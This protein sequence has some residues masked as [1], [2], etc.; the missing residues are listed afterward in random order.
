MKKKVEL[1]FGSTASGKSSYAFKRALAENAEIINADSMQIYKELPILTAQPSAFEKE[2]VPHH[3][4]GILETNEVFSVAKWLEK[5]KE[6]IEQIE[7]PF[8]VGGTG[9]YFKS[10][11]EGLSPIPDIEP[12]VRE[13]VRKMPLDEIKARL[14][15]FPYQDPQRLRRAFEVFIQTGKPLS[16]FQNLP[17]IKVVEADFKCIFI[18]PKREILYEK[19]ENRFYKMVDMGVLEEIENFRQAH[20]SSECFLYHALGL[21]NIISFMDGK[22]SFEKAIE[23]TLKETRHYAKRQNTFFRNQFKSHSVQEIS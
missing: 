3:L 17:K 12:E 18:N 8:L 7:K 16:Y 19:I 20:Y 5:V 9:F 11:L 14:S 6:K 22:I 1:I 15:S 23:E 21:K 2:K 10:L 4:Y 13:K